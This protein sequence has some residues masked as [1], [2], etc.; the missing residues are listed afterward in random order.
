M[1]SRAKIK[2]YSHQRAAFIVS[3]LLLFFISLAMMVILLWLRIDWSIT[4]WAHHAYF[5]NFW[6]G[7]YI[8]FAGYWKQQYFSYNKGTNIQ[9]NIQG[10]LSASSTV[11]W[12][13]ASC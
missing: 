4:N 10:S 1:F 2:R 7:I 3:K 8:S 9:T 6:T 11:C 12:L 13:A 5:S